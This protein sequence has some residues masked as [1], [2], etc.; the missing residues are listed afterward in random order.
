[1]SWTK[2]PEEIHLMREGGAILSAALKVAVDAVAPG[3]RLRDL[4]AAAEASMRAAGA[5]PSFL[6]Y[7]GKPHDP[8]FP[9]TVCISVNE[10][11]V[12]GSGARDRELREGDI[13]GLDIGCW[14]K[15]LCTDMAV[16]VPVGKISE[17][18]SI[19][20]RVTREAMETAV[21]GLRVGGTVAD[22]GRVVER[23]VK[24]YKFGIV[25]ALV[26]HGVGH[27]V[28]EA[29]HVPNYYDAQYERTKLEEGQCLAV[30]PMVTLGD[31][32]VKTESDGW[33]IV[34]VDGSLGAHFE[35]SLALVNGIPEILTP[36]PV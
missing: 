7:K 25:R 17:E 14:Y 6:G 23:I 12:H 2:T 35:V 26:G 1:M 28:H 31:Y 36:L 33:S 16:T 15:G 19:L 30:E 29:P 22:V 27:E 24:P 18:A 34:T 4:D 8:P 5:T 32:H 3:V 10:E 20:L 11:V 13:V 21:A 9:S